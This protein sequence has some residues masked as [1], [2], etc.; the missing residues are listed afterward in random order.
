MH[1]ASKPNVFHIYFTVFETVITT[2]KEPSND[3]KHSR[4]GRY[5]QSNFLLKCYIT[6]FWAFGASVFQAQ[7]HWTSAV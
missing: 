5:K 1:T 7:A 3:R 6:S 2:I 4:K